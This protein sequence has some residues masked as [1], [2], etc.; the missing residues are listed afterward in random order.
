MVAICALFFM[1]SSPFL[2]AFSVLRVKQNE[3]L[4][5]LLKLKVWK[6][7]LQVDIPLQWRIWFQ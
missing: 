3:S 6:Y 7:V 5:I 1:V 2:T 4:V